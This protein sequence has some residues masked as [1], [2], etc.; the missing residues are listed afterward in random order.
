MVQ[1]RNTIPTALALMLSRMRP[2]ARRKKEKQATALNL[3]A[4]GQMPITVLSRIWLTSQR[5]SLQSILCWMCWPSIVFL[6]QKI[7]LWL[8]ARTRS[9]QPSASWIVLRLPTTIKNTAAWQVADISGTQQDPAK[10]SPLSRRHVWHHSCLILIRCCLWL[11]VRTWTTRPWRS[12]TA[13]KKV[14]P[15]AILLPEF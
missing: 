2:L 6:H 7:C 15:T 13:L 9:R 5:L 10:R 4:S 8:C 14:L 12:M 1:I 11:T 3:P